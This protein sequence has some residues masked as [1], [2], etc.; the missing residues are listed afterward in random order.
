MSIED[1]VSIDHSFGINLNN[2]SVK[3]EDLLRIE[4]A[5][6][7]GHF[8]FKDINGW[9]FEHIGIEIFTVTSKC[10]VHK[11]A[12]EITGCWREISNILRNNEIPDD[13]VDEAISTVVKNM[14]NI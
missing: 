13:W 2:I 1:L 3:A 6:S 5:W 7:Q 11:G 14:E 12:E 9:D 8:I 4:R 10:G